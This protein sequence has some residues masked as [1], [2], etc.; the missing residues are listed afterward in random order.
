MITKTILGIML[1][2][3]IKYCFDTY[4]GLPCYSTVFILFALLIGLINL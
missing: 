3:M 1:L 4:D 2:Y